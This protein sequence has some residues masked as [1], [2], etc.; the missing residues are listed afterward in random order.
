MDQQHVTK[1]WTLIRITR[2]ALE[3]LYVALK[4]P[5]GKRIFFAKVIALFS[6]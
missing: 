6:L 3:G 4:Y 2:M 1:M 5:V